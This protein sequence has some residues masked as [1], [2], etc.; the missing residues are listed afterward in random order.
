MVLDY[1]LVI[2]SG[3]AVFAQAMLGLLVTTRPP[4]EQRRIRYEAAFAVIGIIGLAAIICGGIRTLQSS[5]H[6]EKSIG[7]IEQ[8]GDTQRTSLVSLQSKIDAQSTQLTTL[9]Q[10]NG[11]LATQNG[12]L[13]SQNAQ[14]DS[15]L[16]KIAGAANLKAVPAQ[17]PEVTTSQVIQYLASIDQRLHKVEYPPRD[18]NMLYDGPVAAAQVAIARYYGANAT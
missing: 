18:P 15:D 12:Q 13:L 3:L 7:H 10:E 16:K 9:Q 8:S 1:T 2:V 5:S 11:S 17:S 4:S 6:I 14:L